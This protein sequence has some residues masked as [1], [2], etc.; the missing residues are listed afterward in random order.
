MWSVVCGLWLFM[1]CGMIVLQNY[2]PQTA[3]HKPLPPVYTNMKEQ[4]LAFMD[5]MHTNDACRV[6]EWFAEDGSLWIPPAQAVV[7]KTR[8]KALFRAMFSRYEFLRWRIIDILPVGGQRCIHIC[9]SHGKLKGA[10]EY[11]NQVMTDI[12]FNDEGKIASLSDY[13]KNTAV[14]DK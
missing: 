2:R 1:W 3:N 8:I 5:D 9:E 14:F 12:V 7:G 10:S 11:H 4:I 13:F 6:A